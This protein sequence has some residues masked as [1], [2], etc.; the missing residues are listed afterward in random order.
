MR[1][2]DRTDPS[3]LTLFEN[4]SWLDVARRRAFAC[5]LKQADLVSDTGHEYVAIRKAV[6]E[7]AEADSI[8]G[9]FSLPFDQAQTSRL[10]ICLW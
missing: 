1:P 6:I 9:K 2:L 3:A 10:H 8:A 5:V 4:S 7:C